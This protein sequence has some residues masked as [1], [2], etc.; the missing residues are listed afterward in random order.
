VNARRTE[1]GRRDRLVETV[2]NLIARDGVA[3][4]TYRAVAA[5]ADMPIGSMTHHFPTRDDMF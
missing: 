4:A 1:P 5:A 2:L 3:G